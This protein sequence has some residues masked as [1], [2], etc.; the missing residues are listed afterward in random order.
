VYTEAAV[1]ESP[2]SPSPL[3]N[4]LLTLV[5]GWALIGLVVLIHRS[6]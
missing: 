2:V 5:M 4:G 6:S 1:P 3:R